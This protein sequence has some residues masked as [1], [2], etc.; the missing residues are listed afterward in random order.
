[1]ITGGDLNQ[2]V[3]KKPKSTEP[4]PCDP[5]HVLHDRTKEHM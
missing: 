2:Y 5:R 4:M 3:R 1:M